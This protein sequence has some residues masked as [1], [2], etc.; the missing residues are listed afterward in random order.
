MT[1]HIDTLA[2]F[3]AEFQTKCIVALMTDREFLEQSLDIVNPAYFESDGDAWIVE[4]IIWYFT[5]YKELPTMV[6][7]AKEIMKLGEDSRIVY[8]REHLKNVWKDFE[9]SDIQYVKDELLNF[10]KNQAIKNA[11][12]QSATLVET[13]QYDKIKSI[14]D[15]ALQSGISRDLGHNWAEDLDKRVSHAARNTIATR[16]NI[17]NH[18]LDG[19]LGAG[20]LGCIIAP[21]GGG[22]S[23]FLQNLGQYAISQGKTVV[24]F[25]VGDLSETYTGLRYDCI[26]TG[27]EPQQIK[28]NIETVRNAIK[29][30]PGKVFIKYYPTRSATVTVL[31]G[32][33]NR[34][35]QM[36]NKPDLVIVDYADLLL[37]IRKSD[38]KWEGLE[39]VYEELRGMLGELKIPGWTASQSQRSAIQDE[40]I[41]ADKIAGA[42]AKVMVSDVVFSSSRKQADKINNTARIY[43]VKNRFGPDGGIYPAKMNFSTG[44]MGI[45]DEKSIEG[46]KIKAL[47]QGGEMMFKKQLHEKLLDT[48]EQANVNL[49]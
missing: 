45:Y 13:G 3:G 17:V 44:E 37:N 22:K 2:K 11:V 27:I 42:Y 4:R 21:S 33:I 12:I 41:E 1:E 24:H 30:I 5:T 8:I 7:L 25:T 32:F 23:W 20:E 47:A 49:G 16:W 28:N 9:A 26:S 36:G 31:N 14:Y 48:H 19:G 18:I 38:S 15:K 40:I 6:V 34:M 10:C 35:I 29:Q 43:C 46:A 39:Y